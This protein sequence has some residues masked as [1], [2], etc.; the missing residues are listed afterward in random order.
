MPCANFL[1]MTE[2]YSSS[3]KLQIFMWSSVFWS[4]GGWRT[5][6]WGKGK[7]DRES[8]ESQKVKTRKCLNGV[9]YRA[10]ALPCLMCKV[11]VKRVTN[12]NCSFY[13]L[14][15]LLEIKWAFSGF[16]CGWVY[17]FFFFFNKGWVYFISRIFND[18]FHGWSWDPKYNQTEPYASIVWVGY[19][20]PWY[21]TNLNPFELPPLK[22]IL[23]FHSS[24][25]YPL[26]LLYHS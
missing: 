3:A 9:K 1:C 13:V 18:I 8:I 11:D 17:F 16:V 22:S 12:F 7:A 23:V 20:N 19:I 14:P 24:L 5:T 4:L 6:S 25:S 21:P 26:P 15:E 2:R 10:F